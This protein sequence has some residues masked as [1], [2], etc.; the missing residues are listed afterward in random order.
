M[1]RSIRMGLP[2]ISWPCRLPIA[3][4]AD[5]FV[6]NATN[7]NPRL[8]P[9]SRS[10][11]T[12]H[13]SMS[14]NFPNSSDKSRSVVYID[15][16]HHHQFCYVTMTTFLSKISHLH[17]QTLMNV[18]SSSDSPQNYIHLLI[19]SYDKFPINS[20]HS[21]FISSFFGSSTPPPLCSSSLSL[22]LDLSR[23]SLSDILLY[24]N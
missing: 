23:A 15:F 12:L 4:S 24:I 17:L 13:S 16:K 5:S 2:C 14:P 3:A 1:D 21:C 22:D 11:I 8:R 7:A 18:S 19:T 10:R 20:L 9:V 6:L